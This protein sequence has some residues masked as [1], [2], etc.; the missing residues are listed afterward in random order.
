VTA[1][2]THDEVRSRVHIRRIM[3]L[4]SRRDR[5]LDLGAL[6]LIVAGVMV[7]LIAAARLH[8]IAQYSRTN[9]GPARALEAADR[10][11]YASYAGV[12]LVVVGATVGIAAAGRHVIRRSAGE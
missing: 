1:E 6:L 9:P 7:Y 10:A 12:A 4:V 3:T 5:Q 8:G 11:R 2:A